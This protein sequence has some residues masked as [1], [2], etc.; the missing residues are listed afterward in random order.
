MK[1]CFTEAIVYLNKKYDLPE[2]WG[3]WKT[4]D[5]DVFVKNQNKFL[6]RQDHVRFFASFCNKVTSAKTD[7]VVLWKSGVGICINQ[8]CYWTFDHEESAV[9]TR[10]IDKD[11]T[12]MR[13]NN[14]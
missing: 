5:R 14:V 6:A 13:L 9:V 3:G 1:N 8:F 2:G 12:I 7:D 11:C 10:K 4:L